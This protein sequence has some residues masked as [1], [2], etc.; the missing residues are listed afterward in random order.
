MLAHF[1]WLPNQELASLFINPLHPFDMRTWNMQSICICMFVMWDIDHFVIVG[2]ALSWVCAVHMVCIHFP[3]AGCSKVTLQGQS[4]NSHWTL[5]TTTLLGDGWHHSEQSGTQRV[6]AILVLAAWH[7]L[8]RYVGMCLLSSACDHFWPRELAYMRAELAMF[9]HLRNKLH[10]SYVDGVSTNC[11]VMCSVP[12]VRT[13]EGGGLYHK[14]CLLYFSGGL[15]S[16]LVCAYLW[17]LGA[18]RLSI[19]LGLFHTSC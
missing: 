7:N 17:I 13:P 12:G 9:V 1:L 15:V 10:I 19:D 5:G 8:D 3:V 2:Y 11:T 16:Y 18:A 14:L 4:L 6:T